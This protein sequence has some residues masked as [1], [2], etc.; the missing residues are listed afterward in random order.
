MRTESIVLGLLSGVMGALVSAWAMYFV[1]HM[2]EKRKRSQR[3]RCAAFVHF[4]RLTDIVAM[5]ALL[6]QVVEKLAAE[7]ETGTNE[8]DLS[9][10]VAAYL[11]SALDDADAD[12]RKTLQMVILPLIAVATET[13]DSEALKPSDLIDIAP[14]S[15]YFCNRYIA[16]CVGMKV[17]LRLLG[18]F[19]ERGEWSF[20]DA[21][22]LHGIFQSYRKLA[23]TAGVLRISLMKASGVSKG[24]SLGYLQ[25]SHEV[26]RQEV[27]AS[28]GQ[29]AKLEKAKDALESAKAPGN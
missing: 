3:L 4:M 2:I 17:S 12:A 7:K 19:V 28:L 21:P 15:V 10:I 22:L 20:V 5:D 16:A 18:T 26:L 23:K 14:E 13:M 11:A 24:A 29:S 6:T 1:L 8:F 25:R 9:H 27:A